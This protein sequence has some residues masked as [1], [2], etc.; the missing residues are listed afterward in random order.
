VPG[1]GFPDAPSDGT[2]YARQDA[3]W[4]KVITAAD[5]DTA[6]RAAH[7]KVIGD[8]R[9]LPLFLASDLAHDSALS[10][11]GRLDEMQRTIDKLVQRLGGVE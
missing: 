2:P 6:I 7:P 11:R 8:I 10:L 5:V 4:V 1:T 9:A 3:A